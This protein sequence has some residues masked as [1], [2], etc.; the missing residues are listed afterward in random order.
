M[1]LDVFSTHD[2]KSQVDVTQV[3]SLQSTKIWH[4]FLWE[5]CLIM[6]K[7]RYQ[8]RNAVVNVEQVKMTFKQP[9]GFHCQSRM[10]VDFTVIYSYFI[11]TISNQSN[12]WIPPLL[13]FSVSCGSIFHSNP[14][15]GRPRAAWS[16]PP[17]SIWWRHCFTSET[18]S[19][20]ECHTGET[21][22]STHRKITLLASV[23]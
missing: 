9:G 15:C 20:P 23:W 7:V 8:Q 14:F 21:L 5:M 2:R 16:I 1:L 19:W 17:L 22:C 4:F 13:P 3:S 12:A 18:S 6:W 10:A 11:S